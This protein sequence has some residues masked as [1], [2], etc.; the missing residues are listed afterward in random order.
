MDQALDTIGDAESTLMGGLASGLLALGSS[1]V[2][3]IA[4]VVLGTIV[5]YYLLKDGAAITAAALD[6]R[7]NE[8][9][10]ALLGRLADRAVAAVA[11]GYVCLSF[12]RLFVGRWR[13]RR[14]FHTPYSST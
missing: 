10:R 7:K 3:V 6:R 14:T 4:G 11:T 2:A 5:L 1:F 12:I 9:D 8:G 13:S